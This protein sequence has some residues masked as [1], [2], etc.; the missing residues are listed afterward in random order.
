M[1]PITSNEKAATAMIRDGLDFVS[2]TTLH[3][4]PEDDANAYY[5]VGRARH[6]SQQAR[7]PFS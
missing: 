1:N 4:H 3:P 7:I 2:T 6:K 5:H